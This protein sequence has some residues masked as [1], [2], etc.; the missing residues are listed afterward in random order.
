MNTIG[1]LMGSAAQ[2]IA[3]AAAGQRAA[4]PSSTSVSPG[5]KTGSDAWYVAPGAA[6]SSGGSS[7][8]GGSSSSSGG[9]SYGG[10]GSGGGYSPPPPQ[11]FALTVEKPPIITN[12]RPIPGELPKEADDQAKADY[13]IKY[14]DYWTGQAEADLSV[15]NRS[16]AELAELEAELG[17]PGYQ[18]TQQ[19]AQNLL[20]KRQQV[21]NYENTYRANRDKADTI[22]VSVGVSTSK[23]GDNE[24]VTKTY[25]ITDDK[26]NTVNTQYS[27]DNGG[28]SAS[29]LRAKQQADQQKALDASSARVAA[30]A[31][32]QVDEIQAGAERDYA[33]GVVDTNEAAWQQQYDRNL[34]QIESGYAADQL[35]GNQDLLMAG[36]ETFSNAVKN[37][38][39]AANILGQ[40]NLGGSSLGSRLSNIATEAANDANR[41]AALTY[42][43]RM[44]EADRNYGDARGQLEDVNAA[45]RTQFSNDRAK[46]GADYFSRV[47]AT[48]GQSAEDMSRYANADYWYGTMFNETGDR[49]NSYADMDSQAMRDY[50]ANKASTYDNYMKQYLAQQQQAADNQ[51]K[52]KGQAYVSGY[53]GPAKKNYETGLNQYNTVNTNTQ[54]GSQPKLEQE[55]S[56]L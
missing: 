8:G 21:A 10:G 15:W 22:N 36:N 50:A 2:R 18:M 1:G 42:N 56:T 29:E 46:A 14:K 16:R 44:Q 13:W 4:Q 20:N 48:A 19:D 31:A 23:D 5:A 47:G 41:V 27:N 26:G 7:G 45:Q 3:Q 30:E 38:R 25:T 40:Y 12:N 55:R 33:V 32:R 37:S 54:F 53:T 43:Q 52:Q 35:Q 11:A 39:E 51:V 49:L 9:Y 6:S 34:G 24:K 28:M 17:A